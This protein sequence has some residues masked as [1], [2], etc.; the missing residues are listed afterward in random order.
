MLKQIE[1]SVFPI[2]FCYGLIKRYRWRE[3]WKGS[4]VHAPRE[5]RVIII[6]VKN[7][8]SLSGMKKRMIGYTRYCSFLFNSNILDVKNVPS[9]TLVHFFLHQTEIFPRWFYQ[10]LITH[11]HLKVCPLY[12]WEKTFPWS[13]IFGPHVNST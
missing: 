2:G 9:I 6:D 7:Y 3:R 13:V 4:G 5:R 11:W 12:F 10:I 1:G 8:N